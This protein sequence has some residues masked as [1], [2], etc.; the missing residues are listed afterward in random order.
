M[1]GFTI[2]CNKCGTEIV[3][4]DK[5]ATENIIILGGGDGWPMADIYCPNPDC[6]NCME[7]F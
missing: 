7:I 4:P 1:D 6:D 5:E 3:M 2:R